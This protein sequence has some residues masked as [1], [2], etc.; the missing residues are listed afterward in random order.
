MIYVKIAAFVLWT[1]IAVWVGT[2]P[3][4]VKA[5]KQEVKIDQT[6]IAQDTKQ[7]TTNAK[8]EAVHDQEVEHPPILIIKQPVWLRPSAAIC[9]VPVPAKTTQP[10][11]S[12][13]PADAGPPI[14]LRPQL[15]AFALK[16]ENALSDCRRQN[17]EWPN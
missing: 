16:Y 17:A 14:D 9:D 4:K 7:A 13:R 15:A 10:D 3:G 1:A 12:S 11:S 5:E 6:Q 2:L 8:A